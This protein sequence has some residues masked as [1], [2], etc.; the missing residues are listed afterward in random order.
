MFYLNLDKRIKNKNR[1]FNLFSKLWF[2]PSINHLKYW[3]NVK[4]T[5]NMH[6][7][8]HYSRFIHVSKNLAAKILKRILKY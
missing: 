1:F 4:I 3:H 5:D 7:I 6:G 2:V 8:I